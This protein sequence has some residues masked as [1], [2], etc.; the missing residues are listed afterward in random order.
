MKALKQELFI[1]KVSNNIFVNVF[2]LGDVA[3]QKTS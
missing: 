1:D 3:E 2:R